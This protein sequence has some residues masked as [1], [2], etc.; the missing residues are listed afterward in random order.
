MAK[1]RKYSSQMKANILF[2]AIRKDNASEVAPEYSISVNLVSK[3]KK[4]LIENAP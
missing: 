1:R 2:Q 4:Q 3:W